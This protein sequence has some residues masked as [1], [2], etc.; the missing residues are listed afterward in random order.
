MFYGYSR[1]LQN[2]GKYLPTLSSHCKFSPAY[3][4]P[5]SSTALQSFQHLKITTPLIDFF[6]PMVATH[7]FFVVLYTRYPK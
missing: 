6:G 4:I 7:T 3:T 1:P 2:G 5:D